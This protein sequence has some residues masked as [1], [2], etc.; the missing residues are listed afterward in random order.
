MLSSRPPSPVALITGCSSGIG[1]ATAVY[2]AERGWRVWA[3]ARRWESIADLASESITP[4]VLDVT[5]EASRVAAIQEAVRRAGRL[6]ALVNNAGYGAYGPL[7][8]VSP[9]ETRAQFETN[10]FGALRLCQLVIPTLRAQ[11]G[12][13]IVNVSSVAGRIVFPAGGLYCASKFALEALSDALR[14]ELRPWHIHVI[15]VE[16]GPVQTH[17]SNTATAHAQRFAQNL[18]SP[19]APYVENA[20]RYFGAGRAPGPEVVA[21]VIYKSLTAR[22][23][24]PRYPAT[25]GARA[26]MILVPLIPT[27]WRDALMARAFGLK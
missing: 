4:L 8:E 27:R 23:P 16:P 14:L 5:V 21:R 10:V 18:A 6:D 7:E 26:L 19:Y 11:G 3:T 13:R 20:R 2:L 9:E 12:G 24:A 15:L 17:F 22:H 25:P 1:R